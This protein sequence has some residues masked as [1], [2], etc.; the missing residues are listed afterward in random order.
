MRTRG[1]VGVHRVVQSIRGL[2]AAVLLVLPVGAEGAA[3]AQDSIP[4]LAEVRGWSEEE[5][6]PG[7]AV[8]AVLGV[9]MSL[10]PG[11]ATPWIHLVTVLDRVGPAAALPAVE[12]V[13]LATEGSGSSA[14]ELLEARVELVPLEDR[15]PLLA[16]AALLGERVEPVRA[17]EHRLRVIRDFSD[18]AEVPELR[19]RHA[20][21]LLSIEARREEGFAFLEEL[22]VDLPEHPIAPEARRLL[23]LERTRDGTR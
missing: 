13:A 22:I 6:D 20:R 8:G 14:L 17:S 19:L 9:A 12:A 10:A 15:G 5:W 2:A 3:P 23:Q 11:E 4:S 1:G 16:L 18:A 21:W 7:A